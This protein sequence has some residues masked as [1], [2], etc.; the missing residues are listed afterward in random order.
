M[1]HIFLLLLAIQSAA[2]YAQENDYQKSLIAQ[3]RFYDTART[4]FAPVY[5]ALARQLTQDYGKIK[6]V[7]VDLGGGEGSLALELAKATDLTVKKL[8]EICFLD[9]HC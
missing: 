8:G 6:G 2:S 5:P 1:K 7:A 4:V 9:R 3:F